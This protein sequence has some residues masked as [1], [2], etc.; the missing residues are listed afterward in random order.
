MKAEAEGRGSVSDVCVRRENKGLDLS[1]GRCLLF[2]RLMEEEEPGKEL[3]RS[4]LVK[5]SLG[6]SDLAQQLMGGDGGH[7]PGEHAVDLV[8]VVCPEPRRALLLSLGL[9]AWSCVDI[10]PASHF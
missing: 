4:V 5:A 9:F 6:P 2:S 10:R 1:P 8:W 7:V 3:Q